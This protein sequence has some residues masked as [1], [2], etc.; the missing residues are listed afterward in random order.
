MKLKIKAKHLKLVK[1]AGAVS[2]LIFA[3]FFIGKEAFSKT[4]VE[5]TTPAFVMTGAKLPPTVI[6]TAAFIMTGTK[7]PPTVI[8]TEA[9][10]MTGTKL[11]PT[12]IKTEAFVMTGVKFS[13]DK[14][15][16]PQDPKAKKKI[17]AKPI[18]MT[19]VRNQ[20]DIKKFK[21]LPG[22][23]IEE[24]DEMRDTE[25]D[26]FEDEMMSPAGAQPGARRGGAR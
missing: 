20:I 18:E 6:K 19:G 2:V 21:K 26:E 3:I 15:S 7:L 23:K 12:V 17:K 13:V 5:I 11:P 9:F 14:I 24:K 8:K 25:A 4:G 16:L 22:L 1:I 10:T